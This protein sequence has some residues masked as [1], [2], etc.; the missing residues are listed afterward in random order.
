MAGP[1]IWR[2]RGTKQK[3]DFT[4]LQHRVGMKTDAF[5]EG[6]QVRIT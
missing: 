6:G 2:A 1:V 3:E 5:M 4:E